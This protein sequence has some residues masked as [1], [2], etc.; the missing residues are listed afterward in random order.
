VPASVPSPASSASHSD[1]QAQID[2]I[3]AEFEKRIRHQ[4]IGDKAEFEK[5]IRHQRNT[6][7]AVVVFG[8]ALALLVG[9]WFRW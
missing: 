1:L 7:I 9:W 2:Q 4:R 3:K 8:I 6:F 5:R